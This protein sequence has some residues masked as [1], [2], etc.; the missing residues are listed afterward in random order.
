[1]KSTTFM[2]GLRKTAFVLAGVATASMT[3]GVGAAPTPLADQPIS[4]ADVPA[5]VMLALSVEFPTAITRAHQQDSDTFVETKKYLGYFDPNK[6]YTYISASG[7]FEPAGL[8]GANYT[9]SGQW[10]GNFMNWATMQGIDTFRW[11]LTGGL[12][13][14]DEPKTFA[15]A[16]GSPLGKT[17]LQRAYASTQGSYL[18]SNFPDRFLDKS[19]VK[20]YTGLPSDFHNRR[21]WI[22]NGGMGV[23]VRFGYEADEAPWSQ[24][25]TEWIREQQ[26]VAP[27]NVNVEVCRDQGSG[28]G[29]FLESNCR[30]YVDSAGTKTVWKPAGL[31]QQYKDKMYFGEI[32]RAHV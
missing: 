8:A 27:Y 15:S 9:C 5:N 31:M 16:S 19:L 2:P 22:R 25:K 24:N 17:V 26:V 1:M 29:S 23:Q 3:G 14:T 10:S 20:S 7:Y 11:V 21:L 28:A 18:T 12:R 6:C 30:K 32:G 4:I 13:L